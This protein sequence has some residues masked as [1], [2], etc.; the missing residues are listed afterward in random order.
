MNVLNPDFLERLLDEL[1]ERVA[2]RLDGLEREREQA[3]TDGAVSPWMAIECA[4]AYLD[5]PKQRLYRLTAAGEIPHYKQEG[6]LLFHRG[7]L[8][9]WLGRFG[10]G[11]RGWMDGGGGS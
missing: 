1:A 6:R 3:A 4:A 7:E 8:D 2:K 11:E 5:L 10:E 9:A